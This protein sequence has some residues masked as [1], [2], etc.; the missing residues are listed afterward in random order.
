MTD[1][2]I[3]FSTQVEIKEQGI[4]KDI[5][6]RVDNIDLT[7]AQEWEELQSWLAKLKASIT[8]MRNTPEGLATCTNS[9]DII[10]RACDTRKLY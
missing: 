4:G 7:N 3:R 10:R 1:T 8:A 9:T 5:N 6:I 2:G